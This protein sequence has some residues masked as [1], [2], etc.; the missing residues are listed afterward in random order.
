MKRNT[1]TA[2]VETYDRG[3]ESQPQWRAMSEK[4]PSNDDKYAGSMSELCLFG[5]DGQ[6]YCLTSFH[7]YTIFYY[8]MP[9]GIH[10][11]LWIKDSVSCWEHPQGCHGD[12]LLSTSSAH[13]TKWNTPSPHTPFMLT[14]KDKL[15][16]SN[17]PKCA[18]F[19]TEEDHAHMGRTW[20]R[21]I[22]RDTNPQPF[23]C[24]GLD[25]RIFILN[26]T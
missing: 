14:P 2:K 16:V 20:K 10:H 3:V 23:C 1:I 26:M 24:V 17:W 7:L 8:L 22:P 5:N 15:K 11:R 25:T 19:W 4:K 18:C 13:M 9:R 6:T 12:L 21:H